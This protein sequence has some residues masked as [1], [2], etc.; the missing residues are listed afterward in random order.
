MLETPTVDKSFVD[1]TLADKSVRAWFASLRR[2]HGIAALGVIALVCVA[3]TVIGQMPWRVE[4]AVVASLALFLSLPHAS[5]D[6]YSG[7][8]VLQ[9]RLGKLWPLGF[10]VVYGLIALAVSFGWLFAPG[11]TALVVAALGVVHFGLGDV[12]DRSRLRWLEVLGRGAAPWALAVLFNPAMIASFAGWLIVDTRLATIAVYDYALPA[13]IAWQV[14][15]AIIV[16]RYMW[17]AL[18]HSSGGAALV[19]AEMSM[20]VLAFAVLPPL[21][22]FVLYASLLHAPRHVID[23][24]DRNPRGAT[25]AQAVLRVLRAAVIPTALSIVG[26]VYAYYHVG[27][28]MIPQSHILRL[29]IWIVTAF[30]VPHMLLTLLATRGPGGLRR[31]PPAQAR[32]SA[33][34]TSG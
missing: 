12:E 18:A 9:P 19:A 22:A 25:P 14:A 21:V 16:V 2:A 28:S 34:Q 11:P 4:Y 27:G 10:I 26:L 5:L 13:A 17:G 30:A 23:F 29:G 32:S 33:E 8:I 1:K 15:W 6:Q 20:L 31:V 3:Y 7:F 24:A